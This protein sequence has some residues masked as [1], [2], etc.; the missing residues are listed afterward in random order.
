MVGRGVL[1]SAGIQWSSRVGWLA[2]RAWLPSLL[3]IQLCQAPESW[4][5]FVEVVVILVV[6]CQA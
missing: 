4:P 6:I 1:L 5:P 2:S 3:A